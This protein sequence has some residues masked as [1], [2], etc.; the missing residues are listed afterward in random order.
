MAWACEQLLGF[1]TWTVWEVSR[2]NHD[3][4]EETTVT[5]YSLCAGAYTRLLNARYSPVRSEWEPHALYMR[6]WDSERG[7]NSPTVSWLISSEGRGL[8][9][10]HLTLKLRSIHHCY[11]IQVNRRK[12]MWCNYSFSEP[13]SKYL[14]NI[15][16]GVLNACTLNMWFTEEPTNSSFILT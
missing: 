7:S 5:E 6:M 10:C 12:K 3:V 14:Q 2:R 11:M 8:R 4:E 15:K 9:T 1:L 16:T 13:G